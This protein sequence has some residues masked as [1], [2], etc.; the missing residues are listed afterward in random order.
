[1]SQAYHA[2][3][4]MHSTPGTRHNTLGSLGTGKGIPQACEGLTLL[5]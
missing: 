5:W 4:T 3:G 2:Q 1:V